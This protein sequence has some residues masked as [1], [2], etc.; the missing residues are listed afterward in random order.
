MN[1]LLKFHNN[2]NHKLDLKDLNFSIRPFDNIYK[3]SPE[4]YG[5][6]SKY[7][8]NLL[9]LEEKV[10]LKHLLFSLGALYILIV[11]HPDNAFCVEF[12][13]DSKIFDKY[14]IFP[15]IRGI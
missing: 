2:K 8:H 7:K 10:N 14:S 12:E 11:F 1:I 6:Y 3:C 4:W 9:L 15:S 5:V 13:W